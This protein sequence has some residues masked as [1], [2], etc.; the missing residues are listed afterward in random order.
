MTLDEDVS[1]ADMACIA[2]CSISKIQE[3]FRKHEGLSPA[4]CFMRL[5]M[6]E[7]SRRLISSDCTAKEIS[8][9][10]GF[11]NERYFSTAFRR[12]FSVP[13][14]TYRKQRQNT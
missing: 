2:S 5:K 14:G 11:A 4:E 7:A 12:Y 8:R 3:D 6:E 10:L 9:Q 1:V 13:P